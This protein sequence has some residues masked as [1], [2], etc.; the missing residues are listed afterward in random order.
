AY[1]T[2]NAMDDKAVLGFQVEYHSLLTNDEQAEIV[3][4][5]NNKNVPEDLLQQEKLLK[6][7]IYENDD[8]IRAMLHKIFTRRSIIKKF[9]VQNG[10]PTMAAILTTHS[11]KQA[12]RIYYMLQEMKENGTLFTGRPYDE[13]H[14]LIDSEFPR[15]AITFSTNPDQQDI[16]NSDDELSKIMEEYSQLFNSTP[17]T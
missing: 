1:T 3:S 10:Y 12:K 17:Y 6:T 14:Q 9:N 5:L 8:H 15:V 4:R 7:E 11:I 16:N 2:K 13:R